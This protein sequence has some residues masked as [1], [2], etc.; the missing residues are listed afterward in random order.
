VRYETRRKRVAVDDGDAHVVEAGEAERAQLLAE[1]GRGLRLALAALS[2]DER[3]AIEIAY[4]GDLSHAETAAKLGQPL[5]TIKTR[6]RAGLT[7]LR[8]ALKTGGG[9][10]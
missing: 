7:K 9:R 10:S 1:Q 3:E 2:A 6:I 5:G 4:F 8:K